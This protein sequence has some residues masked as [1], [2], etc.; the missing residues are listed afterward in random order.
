MKAVAFEYGGNCNYIFQF[1]LASKT[2]VCGNF[3]FSENKM[4]E[5]NIFL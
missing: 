5:T 1:I 3:F 2:V 4:K